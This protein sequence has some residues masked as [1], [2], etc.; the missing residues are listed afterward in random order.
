V[1]SSST[2]PLAGKRVIITRA[3]E[4]GAELFKSLTALGALPISLPLICLGPPQ[5]FAPLDAGL[6]HLQNFDWII[7]TSANAVRAVASRAEVLGIATDR[8]TTS[9]LVAV[10]GPMTKKEA[11][12]A[13]FSVDYVA[14]THLGVALAGELADLLRGKSVFLP[15]SDRA[16]PDLPSALVAL[17]VKL[18]EVVA[19]RTMATSD[20]DKQ[21]VARVVAHESDALLFFSP[22]AV[23]L[24]ADILGRGALPVLQ[25]KVALVAIGPV[26]ASALR[27]AGANRII[28]AD[29]TTSFAV[30]EALQS[31]FAAASSSAASPRAGASLR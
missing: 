24:L 11:E 14:K 8:T 21:H 26:T 22:S 6:R 28:V 13:G 12:A 1:S 19:Y 25:H 9:P 23:H 29:D 2:S 5:D 20:L 27:E 4:Q 3:V 18:S 31:H 30:V 10:I 15:R 7:F 16:N 17:D